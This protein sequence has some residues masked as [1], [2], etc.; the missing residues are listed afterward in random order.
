MKLNRSCIV[1]SAVKSTVLC[2]CSGVRWPV[3][4]EVRAE[5]EADLESVLHFDDAA[6]E[7]GWT[8]GRDLD[9][10]AVPGLAAPGA[11]GVSAQRG[12]H[13]PLLLHGS[14]GDERLR[15]CDVGL[16]HDGARRGVVKFG[17]HRDDFT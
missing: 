16:G 15:L 9:G 3:C 14:A 5:A 10:A 7:D 12:H 13:R 8:D 2:A 4:E 17:E 1:V 11:H 6:L